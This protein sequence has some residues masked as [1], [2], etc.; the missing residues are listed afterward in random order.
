MGLDIVV[1]FF[2]LGAMAQLLRAELTIPDGFYQS[3]VILLLLAIGLKGGIALSEHLNMTLL[4]Q[5]AAIMVMGVLLPLLAV[6][7]LSKLG[8]LTKVTAAT[9]AAHYG[10]VS[11]ATY[12]VGVAFLESRSIPYEPYFPLFVALLEV[13]AIAVGLW[14]A[15]RGTAAGSS[16]RAK[17]VREVLL[18]QG[19]VLLMGGLFIGWWAGER[20]EKI[21]PLF[22]GLFHGVLALFLLAMGQKAAQRWR[23]LGSDASFLASFGIAMPLVGAL[24]GT[25]FALPLGLSAGGTILLAVLGASASYIAVPAAFSVA[26]PKADLGPAITAS[27]GVTFPFNVLVGIP[28]YSALILTMVQN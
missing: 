12:A 27:L 2:I 8:G 18:N 23:E 28:L 10:S 7:I 6:P 13:P 16:D 25:A 20:T 17:L 5:G 3:L 4:I 14:L 11:V 26:M 19:M 21:M 1:A 24:L 9:I 22:G 15:Q